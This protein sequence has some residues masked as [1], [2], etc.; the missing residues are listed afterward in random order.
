MNRKVSELPEAQQINDNDV[1]MILQSN[2][3]KKVAIDKLLPLKQATVTLES[4]VNANTDYTL[5]S[6]MYYKVG[7]N[8]LEVI[9]CSTK[10][11]KGQDYNEIG[12]V[13]EV[14]NVIQFTDSIG[15]LN[16]SGVEGFEDFEET[17]EFIVR[18]D[19]NAS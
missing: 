19:Y 9:Y 4:T 6:G 2:E 7:N 14:S 8:S 16:M 18:G 13:G 3:N 12:N 11:V 10:L 15:D 17:L 1:F 5:P